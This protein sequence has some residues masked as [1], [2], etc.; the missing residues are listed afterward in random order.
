MRELGY[1]YRI[2]IFRR[3]RNRT[4]KKIKFILKKEERYQLIMTKIKMIKNISA[5]Q[6]FKRKISSNH[7]YI[8]KLII[9][10][11]KTS[12][13]NEYLENE[14]NFPSSLHTN[15]YASILQTNGSR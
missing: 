8:T 6:N 7:L 13:F 15:Y 9:K 14:Y 11:L 1:H 12:R 3:I 4:T 10:K 5:Y 2:T